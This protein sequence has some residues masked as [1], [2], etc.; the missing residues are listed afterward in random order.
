MKENLNCLRCKGTMEPGFL[1]D[2]G[3]GVHYNLM[4][5]KGPAQKSKWVEGTVKMPTAVSEVET[6]CCTKC[7]YLESYVPMITTIKFE[8]KDKK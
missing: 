5:V 4:W 7:G 1:V 8:W 6:Y 2:H 3:H